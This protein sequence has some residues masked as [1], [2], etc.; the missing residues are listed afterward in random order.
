MA[1]EVMRLSEVPCSP[2]PW[3]KIHLREFLCAELLELG[4][5]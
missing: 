1:M 2:F 3:G 5:G 4:A